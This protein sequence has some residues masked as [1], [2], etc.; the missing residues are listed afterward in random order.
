MMGCR[1]RFSLV[2]TVVVALW[3]PGCGPGTP[4]EIASTVPSADAVDVPLDQ[5]LQVQFS[6]PMDP[7]TLGAGGFSVDGVQGT[8]A[9]DE[10]SRTAT[11]TPEVPLEPS[12][13]YTARVSTGVKDA[14]GATL[15]SA[16]AWTFTTVARPLALQVSSVTPL[17]GARFIDRQ[18]P[19]TVVFSKAVDTASLEGAIQVNGAGGT[20]SY[21]AATR[22]A[23]FVPSSPLPPATSVT[24]TLS[25]AARGADG[26]SLAAPFSW[27]FRTAAAPEQ[28]SGGGVAKHTG[29]RMAFQSS[30]D[31]LAVWGLSK[32]SLGGAAELRYATY[33][34]ATSTWSPDAE[35]PI[36]ET[37]AVQQVVAV[38]TR[39]LA[40]GSRASGTFTM[41]YDQGWSPPQPVGG[42]G[43]SLLTLSRDGQR[44]LATYY[45]GTTLLARVF[46]ATTGWSTPLTVTTI[47]G[48]NQAA[49]SVA[50]TTS[51]F[52]LLVQD[53]LD[54]RVH[55]F[56]GTSW[57]AGTVV[58]TLDPA[59]VTG[60]ARAIA[61]T[62]TGYAVVWE[63]VTFPNVQLRARVHNGTALGAVATVGAAQSAQTRLQLVAS[64][65]T[66]GVMLTVTPA[67]GTPYL[68]LSVFNGT[69]WPAPTSAVGTQPSGNGQLF[70]N[71]TSW[72]VL[73]SAVGTPP[74]PHLVA[75]NV[76]TTAWGTPRVLWNA[77][78]TIAPTVLVP[79]GT[80]YW[81]FWSQ[82]SDI[83]STNYTGTWSANAV[84]DSRS[85]PAREVVAA[86]V[87]TRTHLVWNQGA[88]LYYRLRNGAAWG[89]ALAASTS[90]HPANAGSPFLAAGGAGRAA[91]WA[92]VNAGNNE[93][94]A[95]VHR[96]GGW[97]TRTR[98]ADDGLPYSIAVGDTAVVAAY[99][100]AAGNLLTRRFTHAGGWEAEQSLETAAGLTRAATAATD[101]TRFAVLFSQV[102][103]GV[104]AVISADGSSWSAP[105][106][107]AA[108]QIPVSLQLAGGPGGFAAMYPMGSTS[109]QGHAWEGNGPWSA[110]Q[111]FSASPVF[112]VAAQGA[113]FVFARC[114]T[115]SGPAVG[116]N[117]GVYDAAAHLWNERRVLQGNAK[118][119]LLAVSDT[120]ALVVPDAA[121]GSKPFRLA[122]AAWEEHPDLGAPAV[123]LDAL[124]SD[125]TGGY[126]AVDV[127]Q[128][129]G[130]EDLNAHELGSAGFLAARAIDGSAAPVLPGSQRWVGRDGAYAAVWTSRDPITQE[131]T[132]QAA[133]DL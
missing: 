122:G 129:N 89:T 93:V 101:G 70:S 43:F 18:G 107:L 127:L 117:L 53:G 45:S 105:V 112:R 47:T 14:A 113:S 77:T 59:Q 115:A 41:T 54:L 66:Y 29:P 65:S 32:N 97:G 27:S 126:A 33:S 85:E 38:G 25:A 16:Y 60:F 49:P 75:A 42:T 81:A 98:L 96:A 116:V 63:S 7:S 31:G 133:T 92:Q 51:G 62:G 94:W 26:V 120:G 8:V 44:A 17:A 6:R 103:T 10:A 76:F 71:G 61:S 131:E 58:A 74:A 84:V 23:T 90:I 69:A 20:V 108:G 78:G 119:C 104:Q 35:F 121:A 132:V 36:T 86:T 30:G 111:V 109:V 68:A 124:A 106:V 1:V 99:R 114:G 91:L 37:V 56:D 5:P 57:S 12:T 64:N 82:G 22:T 83:L 67:T 19:I 48:G 95:N 128:A 13:R 15:S 34:A 55:T 102:D 46:S 50:G 88:H 73:W 21:D 72:A 9:Y 130:V 80:G 118:D 123:S 110:A 3:M 24:A 100:D 52:A 125:G 4:V 40:L 87:G 28:L 39:Y 11:F 79:A 2:S